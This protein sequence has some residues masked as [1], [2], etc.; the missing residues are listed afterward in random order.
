MS[1]QETIV[2][3]EALSSVSEAINTLGRESREC[4]E[5]A[6]RKIKLNA[7]EWNDEDFNRLLSAINSFLPKLDSLDET[8]KQLIS[9][10]NKKIDY[11]NELH[12]KKI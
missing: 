10:I 7:E 4:L 2:D 6:I 1:Q 3:L 11:I 8:N 9:R 12:S 5:E